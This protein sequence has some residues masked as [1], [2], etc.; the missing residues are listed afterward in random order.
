LAISQDPD[1]DTFH[2]I[3]GRE[4]GEDYLLLHEFRNF[5]SGDDVLEFIPS[6]PWENIQF[7]KVETLESPSWVSWREIE[8][9][10]PEE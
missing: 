6:K 7:I 9:L 8:I 3:W 10:S 5:T 2:R 1:G 4:A